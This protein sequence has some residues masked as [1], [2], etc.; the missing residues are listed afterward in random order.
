MDVRFLKE[1][2]KQTRKPLI[3]E[4]W[5]P[6]DNKAIAKNQGVFLA[7]VLS[8]DETQTRLMLETFL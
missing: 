3:I 5:S 4:T 6:Q 8:L 2:T 7:C 1:K